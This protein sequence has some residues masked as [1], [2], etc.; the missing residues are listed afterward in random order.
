MLPESRAAFQGYQNKEVNYTYP[1][2]LQQVPK[3]EPVHV[4]PT[5]APHVPSGLTVSF[6]VEDALVLVDV[7]VLD[8]LVVEVEDFVDLTEL[9]ELEELLIVQEPNAGWQP[10]PQ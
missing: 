7:E 2:W 6:A 1:Y 9:D 5:V 10:V 4:Y 8:C 3:V